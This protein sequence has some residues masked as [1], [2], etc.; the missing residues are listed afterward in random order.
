MESGNLHDDRWDDEHTEAGEARVRH[1]GR[2]IGSELLGASVYELEPGA[3]GVPY[4]LHHANEELLVVVS[5]T[6]TVRNPDGEAGLGPGDVTLFPRGAAGAHQ[7]INRS[8]EPCRFLLVSTMIHPDVVQFPD[9][10]K[11]GVFAG[12]ATGAAGEFTFVSMLRGDARMG[13]WEGEPKP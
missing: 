13:F 8:D 1:L 2:E 3:T 9:T 7:V 6:P 12:K 11:V 10:G 4:H 5:G